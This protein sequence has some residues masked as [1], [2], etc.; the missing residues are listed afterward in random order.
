MVTWGTWRRPWMGLIMGAR[1]VKVDEPWEPS[2][3]LLPPCAA[4]GRPAPLKAATANSCR[5]PPLGGVEVDE[6][7]TKTRVGWPIGAADLGA[8]QTSCARHRQRGKVVLRLKFP[9]LDSPR[10]QRDQR[11]PKVADTLLAARPGELPCAIPPS[12]ASLERPTSAQTL[13]NDHPKVAEKLHL[14][15]GKSLPS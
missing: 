6:R 3:A 10:E 14:E 13:P 5:G 8:T 7:A 9:P 2:L 11:Y 1:A 4:Y 12:P 15:V